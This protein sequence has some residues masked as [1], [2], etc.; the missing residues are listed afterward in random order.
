MKF[1]KISFIVI[2]LVFL[3]INIKAQNYSTLAEVLSSGGS[4][5]I[6]SNYSNFGVVGETFV[7]N[8]VTGG[9]YNNSIGFLYSSDIWVNIS[10]IVI[11]KT[12]KIFPNPTN[13][14]LNIEKYNS[15]IREIAIYNILGNKVFE[16]EYSNSI[17]ISNLT[18]GLYFLRIIE[19]NG[20][21]VHLEKIVKN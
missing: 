19:N 5:S 4:E 10:E 1:I 2:A 9:N 12:I 14:I 13:E 8:S 17:N 16:S 11:D 20:S 6:G 3:F 21:V 15:S 7:N 18:N